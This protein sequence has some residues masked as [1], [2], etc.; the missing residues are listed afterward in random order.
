[1]K[2]LKQPP[3]EPNAFHY[4]DVPEG[5]VV[6]VM[7]QYTKGSSPRTRGIYLSVTPKTVE[8]GFESFTMLAGKRTRIVT[9]AR[10][11][12]RLLQRLAEAADEHV[13]A[14]AAAFRD[15]EDTSA[16]DELVAALQPIAES[17]TAARV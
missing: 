14:V 6:D 1:M 9:L 12:P 7:I 5:K 10:S 2:N 15:G 16:F 13:P 4:R 8:N 17:E 3:R 11:A